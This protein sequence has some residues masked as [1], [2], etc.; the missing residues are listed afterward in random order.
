MARAGDEADA[1]PFE[2]V[3]GI[4]ERVIS[5]SQ[6]LHEPASTWRMVSA[7]ANQLQ[8][9]VF[10]ALLCDAQRLVGCGAAR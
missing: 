5:S 8:H 2:V 6:P 9:R 1:Q 3:V 10:E 7:P 4:V